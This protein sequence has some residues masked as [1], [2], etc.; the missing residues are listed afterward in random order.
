MPQAAQLPSMHV[1][2]ISRGQALGQGCLVE[3][4]VV[5]R[6]RD[7]ADVH[8]ALDAI[9]LQQLDKALDW[10]RRM[11]KSENGAI[12]AIRMR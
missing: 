2:E 4:R 10:Q 12:R 3:L 7:G 9:G 8:E 11:P 5:P 6:T 1:F